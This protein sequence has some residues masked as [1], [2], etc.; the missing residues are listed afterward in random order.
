MQRI[1]NNGFTWIDAPFDLADSYREMPLSTAKYI[2]LA[3]LPTA[4]IAAFIIASLLFLQVDLIVTIPLSLLVT[5]GVLVSVIYPKI[6]V[7]QQKAEVTARFH[8]FLTHI[9]VLSTSNVDRI[10]VFRR[11]SKAE[12]Y[13]PLADEM[14]NIVM[15]V[16]TWNQ[17]LDDACRIR[18][19]QVSS[20]LLSDFLERMSYGLSAGR[21]LSEFLMDEQE[22]FMEEF[23]T[24]YESDLDTLD[25]M[26]DLYVSLMLTVTFIVVFIT[27]LPLIVGISPMLLLSGVIL[28]FIVTQIAFVILVNIVTPTDPLWVESLDEPPIIQIKK[29]VIV[30]GV[31]T[32]ATT[33]FITLVLGD[34]FEWLPASTL[35]TPIWVAIAIT[36]LMIVGVAMHRKEQRIIKRDEAFPSFIRALGNVE[37]IKKTSTKNVLRTFA[38]R[39]FGEL[40]NNITNLNRR[41]SVN[42]N[43]E[44]SWEKFAFET[45]SYLIHK[46]SNMYSIGRRLGA[47]SKHIGQLISTNFEQVKQLRQKRNNKAKTFIGVIYGFTFVAS[48]ALFIGV[49]ITE[50]MLELTADVVT[51]DTFVNLILFAPDGY[52]MFLIEI[53]LILIIL[54]NAFFSSIIIRLID[55]R[56][57]FSGLTHF[58][59]LTWVGVTSATI[60]VWVFTGFF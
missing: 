18:S 40:T 58:V 37:S 45:G 11:L 6:L 50:R 34:T 12:A 33:F 56:H 2:V 17:S 60:T 24:R 9:T 15:L 7:S 13:G 44:R 49:E 29:S 38:N 8:L 22:M 55:Q 5:F 48:A 46:F 19:N 31:I 27:V 16:D 21:E 25:V 32:I 28:L 41:L 39:D 59:A 23:Y 30:G 36:P 14:E 42:I 4:V 53:L 47:N 35:P 26:K 57:V 52:N 3:V 1:I 20:E 10:E 51:D 54:A 43:V